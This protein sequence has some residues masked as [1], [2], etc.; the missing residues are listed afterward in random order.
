MKGIDIR[1]NRRI[2][3]PMW[4]VIM[5]A[6]FI[7]KDYILGVGEVI[8]VAIIVG[9][10]YCLGQEILLNRVSAR[11][12]G[13]L[14]IINMICL[15]FMIPSLYRCFKLIN[16]IMFVLCFFVCVLYIWLLLFAKWRKNWI[17]AARAYLFQ[18]IYMLFGV[19]VA[20]LL[21]LPQFGTI[22]KWDAQVYSYCLSDACINFDYT[23]D[24]FFRYFSIASHTSWGYVFFSSI[25]EFWSPFSNYTLSVLGIV[26]SILTFAAIYEISKYMGNMSPVFAMLS[27]IVVTTTPIFSGTYTYY[28]L[29]FGVACLFFI[30]VFCWVK[31]YELL[32]L[33]FSILFCLTKEPIGIL[34]VAGLLLYNIFKCYIRNR[35]FKGFF[36]ALFHEPSNYSFAVSILLCLAGFIKIYLNSKQSTW[37]IEQQE[38]AIGYFDWNPYYMQ[39]KGMQLVFINFTWLCICLIIVLSVLAVVKKVRLNYDIFS[40]IAGMFLHIIFS[41]LYYTYAIPRYN[42]IVYMII[43]YLVCYFIC[44]VIQNAQFK[45]AIMILLSLLFSVQTYFNVDFIMQ[46]IFP[47][48]STGKYLLCNTSIDQDYLGDYIVYNYMYS[49][50]DNVI[51]DILSDAE[52]TGQEDIFIMGTDDDSFVGGNK[53]LSPIYFDK[54]KEKWSLLPNKNTLYVESRDENIWDDSEAELSDK[55]LIIMI[56]Y[57]KFDLYEEK[58]KIELRYDIKEQR[59]ADTFYGNAEYWVLSRRN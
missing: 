6:A 42:I 46:N 20:I 41:L 54:S 1:I 31:K 29:D 27:A 45:C 16:N 9:S 11:I 35:N 32:T 43:N 44:L 25:V 36:Y 24:T 15:V 51:L 40:L 50:F 59:T 23:C 4:I 37:G 52:Y 22:P 57:Y 3:A 5:I 28:T 55:A 19:G 49:Y 2:T 8:L 13:E 26:L 53:I 7:A 18:N 39:I 58:A 12:S 48:V 21:R 10:T 38:G 56:P 30:L 34:F 14:E 47:V 33:L 17:S